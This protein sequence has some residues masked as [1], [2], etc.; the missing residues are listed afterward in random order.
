MSRVFADDLP[1]A[2]HLSNM[3][4]FC[5]FTDKLLYVDV[6]PYHRIVYAANLSNLFTHAKNLQRVTGFKRMYNAYNVGGMFCEN[7]FLKYTDFRFSPD[8]Y[9]ADTIFQSCGELTVDINKMFQ[10][11][12]G[13]Y[14]DFKNSYVKLYRAFINCASLTGT[15]AN[16]L[17]NILWGSSKTTFNSTETFTN[18]TN[19][20]SQVPTSWGGTNTSI[21]D[22]SKN[23]ATKEYVDGEIDKIEAILGQLDTALAVTESEVI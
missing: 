20:I 14:L 16:N 10:N 17:K 21:T 7:Q 5:A 3:S 12:D 18:A 15:I 8:M 1:I 19:L 4:A 9:V 23:I 13:G 2:S 22:N 6:P 11:Q